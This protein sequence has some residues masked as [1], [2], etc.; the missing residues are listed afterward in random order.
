MG[1]RTAL[2]LS[3]LT[4]LLLATSPARASERSNGY[5]TGWQLR[6]AGLA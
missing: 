3:T 6:L 4:T 5:E 1:L 2:V